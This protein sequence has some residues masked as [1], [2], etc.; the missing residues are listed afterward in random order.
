MVTVYIA[1]VG[2]DTISF[3]FAVIQLLLKLNFPTKR[4]LLCFGTRLARMPGGIIIGKRLFGIY[5]AN[6]HFVEYEVFLFKIIGLCFSHIDSS[7][8]LSTCSHN[9]FIYQLLR[10]W[11]LPQL[12]ILF[13]RAKLFQQKIF[14]Q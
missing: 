4:H 3:V 10:L 8:Y 6:G 1:F 7:S 11:N 12:T 14:M 5:V 9:G 2:I 13:N